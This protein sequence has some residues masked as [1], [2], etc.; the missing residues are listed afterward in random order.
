MN[1]PIN[2]NTIDF[3]KQDSDGSKT[4]SPNWKSLLNK[5]NKNSDYFD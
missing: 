2:A 3:K 1:A 4:N 5:L